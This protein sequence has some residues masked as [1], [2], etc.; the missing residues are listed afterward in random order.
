MAERPAFLYVRQKFRLVRSH[1]LDERLITRIFVRR[2]PEDHFR[3]HRRQI[4]PFRC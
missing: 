4:N 1:E 2:R 3:E